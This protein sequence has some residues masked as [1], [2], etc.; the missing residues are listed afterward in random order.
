MEQIYE[1]PFKV[2]LKQY[3]KLKETQK[4]DSYGTTSAGSAT[5]SYGSLPA[6]GNFYKL[7]A[8]TDLVL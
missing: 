4:Q 5:N 6:N 1:G 3:I 7:A 2:V 8:N